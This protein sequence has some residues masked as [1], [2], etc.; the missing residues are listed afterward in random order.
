[1]LGIA[2]NRSDPSIRSHPNNLEKNSRFTPHRLPKIQWTIIWL[3]G[4]SWAIMH[5]WNSNKHKDYQ[6]LPP[7]V[8]R[9]FSFQKHHPFSSIS[10]VNGSD[11]LRSELYDLIIYSLL[12]VWIK[13]GVRRAHR[14]RDHTILLF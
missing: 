14:L 7:I 8:P 1:M 4:M 11:I 10:S 2:E 5:I 13:F 12:M 6:E 3:I 9:V